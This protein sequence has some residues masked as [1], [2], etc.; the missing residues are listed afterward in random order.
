[1][2][3]TDREIA[4]LLI[5]LGQ[6]D[7]TPSDAAEKIYLSVKAGEVE[8]IKQLDNFMRLIDYIK[9]IET[10]VI[11]LAEN[12]SDDVRRLE[13]IQEA[14]ENLAVTDHWKE[15]VVEFARSREQ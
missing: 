4:F 10:L 11:K 3:F 1:M 9:F 6:L 7:N 13:V 2:E 14:K 15:V 5:G 8:S 12:I